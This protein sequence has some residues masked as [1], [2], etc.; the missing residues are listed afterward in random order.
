MTTT[1]FLQQ[2]RDAGVTVYLADNGRLRLKGPKAALT[3]YLRSTLTEYLPDIVYL[4]NERAAIM[5]YDGNMPRD[6]A[7][8]LAAMTSQPTPER[9]PT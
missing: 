6:K 9:T 8:T 7:E 4:F 3:N 5:E 1:E 2:L